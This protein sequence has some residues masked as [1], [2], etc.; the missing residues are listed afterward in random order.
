MNKMAGSGKTQKSFVFPMLKKI[1]E[2][3][4][5]KIIFSLSIGASHSVCTILKSSNYQT[6]IS[7]K[8]GRKNIRLLYSN[9]A[10]D[11][12]TLLGTS[13]PTGTRGIK[14]VSDEQ[15]RTVTERLKEILIEGVDPYH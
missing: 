1:I 4:N 3:I 9:K 6:L 8:I 13:H 11:G 15:W 10:Q 14:K 5:P 12:K 2:K 7:E